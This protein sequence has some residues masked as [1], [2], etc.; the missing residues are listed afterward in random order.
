MSAALGVGAGA[1]V[2]SEAAKNDDVERVVGATVTATIEPVSVGASAA[3]G[4]R[5][6]AAEVR[7]GG[8]GLDPVK[9]VAGA[10]EHL[11]GDF[12]SNT[13]KGKQG[14]GDLVHELI[15]LL[16]GFGDLLRELL[17]ATGQSAQRRLGGVFSP[18]WCPGRSRVQAA[19][20][21]RVGRC[22]SCSRSCAGPVTIKDLI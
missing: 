8:F 12:G 11:A 9:V 2:V 10:D 1:W 16:V 4:D 15:K 3:G 22:R 13:G 6:G 14:R 17:M 18:S 5:S 7:E 20:S 21:F 19:I